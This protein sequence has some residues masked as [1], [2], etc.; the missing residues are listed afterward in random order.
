MI[1]RD[2]FGVQYI[3]GAHV[4]WALCLFLDPGMKV[5]RLSSCTIICRTGLLLYTT[6]YWS[7]W[8]KGASSNVYSTMRLSIVPPLATIEAPFRVIFWYIIEAILKLHVYYVY[9]RPQGSYCTNTLALK[10]WDFGYTKS[11]LWPSR[12]FPFHLNYCFPS[13]YC[14]FPSTI[15]IQFHLY[16]E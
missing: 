8:D 6:L 12:C 9:W 1:K 3:T 11:H 5:N 16:S 2:Q 7:W 10:Y 4:I 13:H 15:L 14:L